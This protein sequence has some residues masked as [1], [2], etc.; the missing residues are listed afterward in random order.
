M[1]FVF[2][3][4]LLLFGIFLILTVIM[5]LIVQAI[6]LWF[7]FKK[8]NIAPWKALIPIYC[9]YEIIKYCGLN[10]WYIGLY[11]IPTINI[12]FSIYVRAAFGDKLNQPM[13][14]KAGLGLL[15]IVF[16]PILAVKGFETAVAKCPNCGYDVQGAGIYCIN[17]G[18]KL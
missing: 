3:I 4:I 11:F 13:W 8:I 10:G 7:I 1:A 2:L 17:C 16:F 12:L 6:P 5:H 9:D 14:V 18:T 15:P